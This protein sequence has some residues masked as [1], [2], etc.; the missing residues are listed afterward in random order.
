[1]VDE[2]DGHHGHRAERFVIIIPPDEADQL[3]VGFNQDVDN[4]DNDVDNVVDDVASYPPEEPDRHLEPSEGDS[5]P[6]P[7]YIVKYNPWIRTAFE[8]GGFPA[9]ATIL[10][11]YLTKQQYKYIILSID[12]YNLLIYILC[13]REFRKTKIFNHIPT[14]PYTASGAIVVNA[15]FAQLM[16]SA[17]CL[18]S[19]NF[20]TFAISF[21]QYLIIQISLCTQ[22]IS[23]LA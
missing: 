22:I 10:I 15:G 16:V 19:L 7:G 21:Y 8:L 11:H 13:C 17:M 2:E 12:A 6:S 23:R 14:D 18:T 20:L 4:V 9:V 3:A 1:M 5:Q